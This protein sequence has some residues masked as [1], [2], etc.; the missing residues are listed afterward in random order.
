MSIMTPPPF[1]CYTGSRKP[2]T[3]EWKCCAGTSRSGRTHSLTQR[4][5]T[6]CES[7]ARSAK[8]TVRDSYRQQ[9]FAREPLPEYI[10]AVAQVMAHVTIFEDPYSA[11][12]DK[13]DAV[14]DGTQACLRGLG[15]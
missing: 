10:L 2:P 7:R 11:I 1:L 6:E 15:D 12:V 9:L 8:E 13:E 3:K 4:Y 14:T 5:R